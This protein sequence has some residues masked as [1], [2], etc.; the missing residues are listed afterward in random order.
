MTLIAAVGHL[1]WY[2][3]KFEESKCNRNCDQ[4]IFLEIGCFELGIDLGQEGGEFHRLG[5]RV[6][7]KWQD[8]LLRENR[9]C[10]FVP[11]E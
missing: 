8:L 3:H 10:N 11:K 5:R 9:C 7:K 1:K 2:K 4:K 6:K